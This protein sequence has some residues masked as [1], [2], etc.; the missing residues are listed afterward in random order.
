MHIEQESGYVTKFNKIK[1]NHDFFMLHMKK[2]VTQKV[3]LQ[4]DFSSLSLWQKKKKKKNRPE[5]MA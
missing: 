5:K 2:K 1:L 3:Q 4:Y